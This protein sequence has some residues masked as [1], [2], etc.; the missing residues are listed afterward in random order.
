MQ[1]FRLAVATGIRQVS[2]MIDSLRNYLAALCIAAAIFCV[3]LAAPALAQPANAPAVEKQFRNWLSQSLW[4][5]AQQK[6]VDAAVFKAAFDGVKL[7]WK[8]PDLVPPGSK[9]PSTQKQLQA[10]F[11]APSAYFAEKNISPVVAGGRQRLSAN[12]A[13]LGRLERKTGVPGRFLLAIWGRESGF[14]AAKIPYNAVEVLA[15]KAFMSTRQEMFTQELVAALVMLSQNLASPAQM[16]SSWAGAM[17]Q[18]QFMPTSYLKHAADGDGD[19]RADI[20]KSDADTLAS[21]ANFLA[22]SGWVAG[23]DWGFEVSVPGSVACHLEGPDRGKPLSQWEALGITR[24]GGKPFPPKEKNAETFLLM[25][26]GRFGPAF[27]VTPNFYVL[28]KYNESDL[29]AL[30][31]GNAA[32]R[33]SFGGT[34]F[35]GNW[36]E[37]GTMLRSDIARLQKF[38]EGKGYDVGGADG[39]PGFKT[40]RSIGEWQQQNGLAPDCFPTPGLTAKAR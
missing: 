34:A 10:E 17:G 3:P 13:L 9:A 24:I 7:N 19:G 31:I 33:I 23:R 5:M 12:Q 18:P 35:A 14:G 11:R 32:D 40:R 15:T 26:A 27:L 39:L 1:P 30:F 37:T 4:P 6:G 22:N 8:L 25:P 2:P 28:K 38:L 36:R 29:Y 16:K 21:M 20:W